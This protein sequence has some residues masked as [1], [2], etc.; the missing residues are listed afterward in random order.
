VATAIAELLL[1]LGTLISYRFVDASVIEV[2]YGG[3]TLLTTGYALCENRRPTVALAVR[4]P[5]L[6]ETLL[7]ELAHA[8]DCLDDGAIN[9]SLLEDGTV[10]LRPSAHCLAARAEFYACWVTEQAGAP[11]EAAAAVVDPPA[12]TGPPSSRAADSR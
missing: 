8:R 11:S 9:G 6:E 1:F 7:H 4:A 2:P 3:A 10:L 5:T 12:R